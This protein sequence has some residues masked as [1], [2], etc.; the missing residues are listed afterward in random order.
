MIISSTIS[1]ILWSTQIALIVHLVFLEGV[2]WSVHSHCCWIV[3]SMQISISLWRSTSQPTKRWRVNISRRSSLVLPNLIW[4]FRKPAIVCL[5]ILI[6]VISW[7]LKPIWSKQDNVICTLI[8]IMRSIILIMFCLLSMHV[9]WRRLLSELSL[10]RFWNLT[11][12][13]LN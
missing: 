2:R 12:W 6:L 5:L 10:R 8:Y 9:I 3:Q 11:N 1:I 13:T 7:L 4:I